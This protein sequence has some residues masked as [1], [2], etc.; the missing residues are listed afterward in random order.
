M[1]FNLK[2]PMRI[3]RIVVFL[4]VYITG[5]GFYS[6]YRNL[7]SELEDQTF[8][9][10]EESLVDTAHIFA[11]QLESH[12]SE[13]DEIPFERLNQA[14][15][16][17][18]EHQFK[19][20][21]FGLEKTQVGCN[22]YI[23]GAD[24][25]I[26]HDS[27]HAERIGKNFSLY[28]DVLLALK[29]EYAVR[30]S[31]DVEDNSNSSVLYVAAPIKNADKEIVGVISVYKAQNDLRPFID[32]RH[33]SILISLALIGTG[34]AAFTIAVFIWLFRPL[35][36]L[37]NY[38]RAI[39]RGERPQYPK[40]G[41]VREANTLGKALRDMRASLDG[42]RY[43]EQYTQML[44][45]E[46][47][48]PLAAIQGASELLEEDMPDHQRDKFLKNIRQETQRSTDIIDG[49]LKLS[50]LEA[51]DSL[52]QQQ[53]IV[54]SCLFS[55]VTQFVRTRLITKQLTLEI[56]CP[57]TLK[58]HGDAMMLE[59]ALVNL[60][61]NAIEFSPEKSVIHLSASESDEKI[62]LSVMDH[63]PGLAP[64]VK[65]RAFEHFFSMRENSKGSGLGLVFVKEVAKLH[66]ATVSLEN[67]LSGGAVASITLPR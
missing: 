59:T 24:G 39:T 63:G 66:A 46:L 36:K 7:T 6:L 12:L 35:G 41:K 25:I 37:T 8:Q 10:T 18:K 58:T 26:I 55:E 48:S 11:A 13:A 52:L 29:D 17:A 4:V 40:L 56:N 42:R 47:K 22:F 38:A 31:R 3:T 65:E 33:R 30:S 32:K 14:L 50:H 5:L 20:D 67:H 27:S 15:G 62:V 53:P 34:I 49:L 54:V 45:H 21:I 16:K 64:F 51:R 9:A 23:T 1:K 28:N 57:E 61:E 19:A 44:T 60:L 2:S 43:M